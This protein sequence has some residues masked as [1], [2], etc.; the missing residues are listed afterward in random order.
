MAEHLADSWEMAEN[1]ADSWDSST[2]IQTLLQSCLYSFTVNES[3]FQ[4]KFRTYWNKN[5]ISTVIDSE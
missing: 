3:R 2:P 5:M 1:L 4:R